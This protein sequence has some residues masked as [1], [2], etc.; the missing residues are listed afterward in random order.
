[1]KTVAPGYLR[2]VIARKKRVIQFLAVSPLAF[3]IVLLFAV[4]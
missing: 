2:V 3:I 4:E 1:M